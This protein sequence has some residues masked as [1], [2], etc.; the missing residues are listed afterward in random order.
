MVP[1]RVLPGISSYP[2]WCS[3]RLLGGIEA[4]SFDDGGGGY[5]LVGDAG[6]GLGVGVGTSSG[7]GA[8]ARVGAGAV[9]IGACTY[10]SPCNAVGEHLSSFT[11]GIK[12]AFGWCHVTSRE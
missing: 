3:L 5:G 2:S 11:G 10:I 1:P 7:V 6:D 9:T 4:T 12:G 8:G